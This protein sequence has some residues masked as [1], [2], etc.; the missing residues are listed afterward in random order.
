MSL[1]ETQISDKRTA[2][3]TALAAEIGE[4]QEP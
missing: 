2:P 3:A 4:R 1:P